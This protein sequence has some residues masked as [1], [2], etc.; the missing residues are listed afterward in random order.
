MARLLVT[1]VSCR[2]NNFAIPSPL[3]QHNFLAPLLC[4]LD[5]TFFG[6]YFHGTCLY[7]ISQTHPLLPQPA[8]HGARASQH[9]AQRAKLGAKPAADTFLLLDLASRRRYRNEQKQQQKQQQ[10]QPELKG[11]KKTHRR[12]I[13]SRPP[14]PRRRQ[15]HPDCLRQRR[16]RRLNQPFSVD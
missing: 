4:C 13:T 8:N 14:N 6:Y 1:P 5:N 10:Q 12:N 3:S 15:A 9:R 7:T 16:R 11:R 2:S